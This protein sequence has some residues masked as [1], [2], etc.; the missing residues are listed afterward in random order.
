MKSLKF[1]K[2][3]A[4]TGSGSTGNPAGY[5]WMDIAGRVN[6]SRNAADRRRTQG[7]RQ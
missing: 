3:D 4:F 7:I 5:I 6:R 2:I 1:K